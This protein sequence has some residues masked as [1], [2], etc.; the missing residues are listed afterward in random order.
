MALTPIEMEELKA[1]VMGLT[2]EQQRFIAGCLPDSILINEHL[3]RY[4]LMVDYYNKGKT[5]FSEQGISEG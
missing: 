2:E 4:W 3:N 5:L 1:R